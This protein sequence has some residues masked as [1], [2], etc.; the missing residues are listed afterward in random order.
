MAPRSRDS[1]KEARHVR[2]SRAPPT[3]TGQAEEYARRWEEILAP[4]ARSIPG[5]R[6]AYFVGDRAANRVYAIFVWDDEPA[7]ALDRAMDDF[8]QRCRDITTGPVEREDYEVLA[9]A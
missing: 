4:R 3:P 7:E 8:R 5:F 2:P 6:A 1:T 9:A